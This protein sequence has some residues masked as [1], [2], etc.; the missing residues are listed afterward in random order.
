MLSITLPRLLGITSLTYLPEWSIQTTF[1]AIVYLLNCPPVHAALYLRGQCRLL[2]LSP[3]I[4]SNSQGPNAYNYIIQA[5]ALH[6]YIHKVGSTTI[7]LVQDL[8]HKIRD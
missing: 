6:I 2:H 8:T 7:Y 4:I 3:G 1:I 5:L